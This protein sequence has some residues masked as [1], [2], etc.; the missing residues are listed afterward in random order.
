M[1]VGQ[2]TE[3][4]THSRYQHL[5]RTGTAVA[6]KDGPRNLARTTSVSPKE[7]DIRRHMSTMQR[8]HIKSATTGGARQG[9]YFQFITTPT[10]DTSRTSLFLHFD[11]RRYL[12][13]EIG[14]GTQRACVQ[15]GVGLRKVRN[16]FLTGQIGSDSSGLIGLILTMADVQQGEV[17]TEG[18]DRRPRLHIHGGPKLLHSMAC[19]RRFVFRTGMPLSVHEVDISDPELLHVPTYEDE[20]I[21][22]W[23]IP[24]HGRASNDLQPTSS[25]SDSDEEAQQPAATGQGSRGRVPRDD[26][27]IQWG[28]QLRRDIVHNM[29]DSDWR[30]DRL[31]TSKFKD[32]KMPATVWVRDALTKSLSPYNCIDMSSAPHLSPESPVLVRNPW[33][34]SLVA[35]LPAADEL[36]N[37]VSMS[38]IVRG[39]PQRGVFDPHKAKS[40]GVKPGPAF[41]QLTSGKSVT[42]E[43]GHTVTPEMVLGPTKPGRGIAIFDIQQHG[44]LSDLEQKISLEGPRLLEG[45]EAVV[46]LLETDLIMSE[47]FQRLLHALKDLRHIISH[48]NLCPNH[49]AFDSSAISS[50]QLSQISSECFLAPLYDNVNGYGASVHPM[51]QLRECID[52]QDIVVA[53][54]GLRI[55]VEPKFFLDSDEVPTPIAMTQSAQALP[56]EV[57]DLLPEEILSSFKPT[58]KERQVQDDMSDLDEPEIITLGTGSAV[59]S[60]YRNVSATLLRM[61][62]NMGNYLFDCGENTLGQLQ[63]LYSQERL[64]H[65]LLNL[66]AIWISHLHADHHLGTL[67][68]L[69]A[70]KSI[71]RQYF[72]DQHRLV[73]GNPAVGASSVSERLCIMGEANMIDYIHDFKSVLSGKLD[74]Y[75]TPVVCHPV[76][77]LTVNGEPFDLK[78]DS[79]PIKDIKTTRVS[80]CYGAQAISITFNNGFKFSYSGDCRPSDSF[81]KIGVDSDV[82]VHEATFDD[83]MDGDAMAK[84]HCTTSEALGVAL[85][86]RAKNVILT[87][88]SQRY[89]KIPVLSN[90]KLPD[91]VRFEEGIQNED[92]AT[93]PVD[94][95]LNDAA[96]GTSVPIDEAEPVSQDAD[97]SQ[98]ARG[99]VSDVARSGQEQTD[100]LDDAPSETSN[101][102]LHRAAHEMNV[103]VAFDYMRVKVSQIKGMKELYPAIEKAF[104][105]QQHGRE[106]AREADAVARVEMINRKKVKGQG[107][108]TPPTQEQKEV[109]DLAAGEQSASN[110]DPTANAKI[111]QNGTTSTEG[112]AKPVDQR[113]ADK[114]S[115]S[116]LKREAKMEARRAIA[117]QR[118]AQAAVKM[119][120]HNAEMAKK[121]MDHFREKDRRL[122]QDENMVWKKVKLNHPEGNDVQVPES[123][124]HG[125]SGDMNGTGRNTGGTVDVEMKDEA[126]TNA[127]QGGP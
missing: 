1:A 110:G 45:V 3:D 125:E 87:H 86:M 76:Y 81:T 83:G 26:T 120:E 38:Y 28:Q 11:N 119:A 126:K 69:N 97:P 61:P 77:G 74:R 70:R 57:R 54:R 123:L 13:G 96:E 102:T 104:E 52:A 31:V 2:W 107:K 63:R 109:R 5:T 85:K 79:L 53:Q 29:F 37:R 16:I 30:R 90:V 43:S 66:R 75:L 99:A 68:I 51:P 114:M 71:V 101:E 92:G 10:A 94:E 19:A 6:R 88:F 73:H 78:Q 47:A 41:G 121:S 8:D 84:K 48:P 82:L 9:F 40:L 93:G 80:H 62:N 122:E 33:P 39:H 60:K 117:E 35:E 46:W 24:L 72:A 20:N 32:V 14:E 59:P 58:G 34:A 23:A 64:N 17:E 65:V 49:F 124:E 108:Q 127:Q 56:P 113:R 44:L 42:T 4:W 111:G 100:S 116:A 67:S 50:I 55:Q 89:Q 12:F 21:Q 27:H 22:V 25:S 15:R 105:L 112:T 91:E 103:C 7:L 118:K 18:S 95:A 98:D 115:K 106:K 36:P